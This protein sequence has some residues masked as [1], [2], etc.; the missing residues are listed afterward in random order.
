MP[1]GAKYR[2]AIFASGGGSNADKICTYFKDHDRISINLVLTN[3]ARAGVLQVAARHSIPSAFVPKGEWKSAGYVLPLLAD[4][5]ITHIV[6]AGFLLLIPDWLIREYPHRIVNIHPALLPR[7]GGKGM[8]GHHV[9]QAVMEAGD[10]ITGIT[11]HEID[12]HYDRGKILFQSEVPISL[13]DTP[14]EIGS[15]VLKAE[16]QFYAPV[17]EKWVTGNPIT[18]N[19]NRTSDH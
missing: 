4:H 17:I 10:L 9:H 15:K 8:Y 7:H 13:T 19:L 12:E 3:Q 2:L 16:H 6:L 5:H 14:E 1:S 11:I 18:R